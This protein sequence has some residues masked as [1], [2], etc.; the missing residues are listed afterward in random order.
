MRLIA[1]LWDF[2]I[3]GGAAAVRTRE[4]IMH[5]STRHILTR[6]GS[7]HLSINPAKVAGAPHR[8]GHNLLD[9]AKCDAQVLLT[10]F[11]HAALSIQRPRI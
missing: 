10:R 3:V 8:C 2:S 7:W 1:S 5:C 6:D 4:P 9:V 11:A